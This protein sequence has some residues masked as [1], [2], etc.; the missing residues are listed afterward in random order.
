MT[1]RVF[2]VLPLHPTRNTYASDMKAT[3]GTVEETALILYNALLSRS[4]LL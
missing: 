3:N 2:H 1:E 4:V